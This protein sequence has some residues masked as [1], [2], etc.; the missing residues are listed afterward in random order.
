MHIPAASALL[1]FILVAAP[2]ALAQPV[3]LLL[4]QER[5][6]APAR[7]LTAAELSSLGDPL[8]KLVLR[9]KA[10]TVSLAEVENLLQPDRTKRDVFVVSE[11]IMDPTLGQQRRSVLTF[12]GT[13]GGEVLDTNVML[14]VFFDSK[15][16]SD[17]P[18][19]IEAWGWDN[20]R[21]RYNYYKLDNTG[22]PNMAKT[23]KFRGS[24]DSADLLS[25][26]DRQGTC[27]ACHINGAPV[28]KELLIPWNNWNSFSSIAGYLKSNA[29]NAWPS[30]KSPRLLGVTNA[31]LKKGGLKGAEDLETPIIASIRQFN[32]RRLNQMLAR[33]DS[34]GNVTT[35]AAGMQQ[36]MDGRRILKHLFTTSE[37]NIVSSRQLSGLHPVPVPQSS[38]PSQTFPVPATAFLNANLIAGGTLLDNRGLGIVKALDFGSVANLTGAE[39]KALVV[40][41]GTQLS[42]AKPADANFAWFVPEP[43]H[44]DNNMVDQAMTMGMLSPGFVAAALSVDLETP[45]L[46][47]GRATLM[48]FMPDRWQF[49]PVAGT[50]LNAHPDDLT[51]QVIARMEKAKPVAGTP[52]ARFLKALQATDPVKQLE[53][54][55]AAYHDRVRKALADAAT[56]GV[57]LKR[58]Y[59]RAIAARNAVKADPVLTQ[60]DETGDALFPVP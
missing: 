20:F 32:R 15:Q 24:S 52:A 33:N 14:S 10:G 41:A 40:D 30:A 27:L 23:W 7:N 25:V 50:S 21:G 36:V 44:I 2:S 18:T 19:A 55:V 26:S 22:T 28:M 56:R 57:E 43:S 17:T 13:V 3:P 45:V 47:N 58:L 49:K 29:A 11:D 59:G 46:S 54:D 35:D 39:Y 31:G 9:N 4:L 5:D 48:A 53:L 37:F 6:N 34:D 51:K 60:L 38:G 8:F 12:S 42:R 1:L 16:F